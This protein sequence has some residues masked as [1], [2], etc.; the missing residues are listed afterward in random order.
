M[1]SGQQEAL[2]SE[3]QAFVSLARGDAVN[4]PDYAAGIESLRVCEAIREAI[5]RAAT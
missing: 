2:L 5:L 1:A 3:L 4:I